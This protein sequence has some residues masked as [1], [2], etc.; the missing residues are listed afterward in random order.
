MFVLCVLYSKDK[1]TNQD[2]EIVQMKYREKNRD[3][4]EI[5]FTRPD[6]PWDPPSLL[7]RGYRVCIPW[8]SGRGVALTTHSMALRYIS[9][10]GSCKNV[11][12]HR[13]ESIFGPT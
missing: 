2:K 7:Y 3:G 5:F 11:Y 13:T 12:F 6:R 8:K 10:R 9:Y 1:R 4:A